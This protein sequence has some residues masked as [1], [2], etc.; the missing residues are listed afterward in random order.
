M[1]NIDTDNKIFEGA[2][3]SEHFYMNIAIYGYLSKI[4]S[5]RGRLP[6]LI[7]MPLD[8]Y[9]LN[10]FHVMLLQTYLLQPNRHMPRIVVQKVIHRPD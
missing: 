1:G 2:P 10:V 8:C 5:G 7:R 3:F 4:S 9:A 6:L